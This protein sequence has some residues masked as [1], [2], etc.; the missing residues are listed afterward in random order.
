MGEAV[1]AIV[2]MKPGKRATA[3]DMINFIHERIA[4]YKT[5][6]SVEFIETCRAIHRRKEMRGG[7]RSLGEEGSAVQSGGD[8][9][10]HLAGRRQ[11]SAATAVTILRL[12]GRRMAGRSRRGG[13]GTMFLN[14]SPPHVPEQEPPPLS[15]SGSSSL[16]SVMR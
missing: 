5:P 10:R 15:A 11:A 16:P 14:A 3:T 8:A 2:V 6:K 9:G 12:Q 13:V 7:T 1:K 4:G